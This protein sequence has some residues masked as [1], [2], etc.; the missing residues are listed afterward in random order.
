ML[1]LAGEV[2]DKARLPL[3]HYFSMYHTL[4]DSAR[5]WFILEMEKL[6][7]AIEESLG[8]KVTEE[9]LRRSISVYNNTRRLMASLDELRKNDP[10]VVSGT[11]YI[12]IVLAGMSTPR[13]NFNARLEALLPELE[14]RTSG[15]PGRPRLM[16]IG[17]ACDAPEFIDFIENK[18]AAIV[19]D[20][21]CFGQRHYQGMVDEDAGEP[22]RAIAD[23]YIN[24]PACPSIINGFDHSFG[25]LKEILKEWKVDGIICARLKFCDHWGGQR[26][27]LTDKLSGN[28]VPLLDLEREYSTKSSGQISTRIQAFLEMLGA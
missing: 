10:P 16:I 12:Q 17:G 8:L 25:I 14:G 28:G 22:L 5:E 6:I 26:K 4:T 27:M 18:G 3:V 9:D 19:A 7:Q 13:A 24:R 11:E 1:R 20:G 21:F 15:E 23:R 2:Q